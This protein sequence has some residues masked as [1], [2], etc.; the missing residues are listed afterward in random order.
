M[1]AI[2]ER[3]GGAIDLLIKADARDGNDRQCAI[4]RDGAGECGQRLCLVVERQGIGAGATGG[5]AEAFK[6]EHR[7]CE[8]QAEVRGAGWRF[9]GLNRLKGCDSERGCAGIA[10]DL[11][12]CSGVE[13]VVKMAVDIAF[14][15][16][17]QA[18]VC[19]DEAAAAPGIVGIGTD[20]RQQ[21]LQ[22]P[23]GDAAVGSLEVSCPKIMK[24]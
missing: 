16:S 2:A 3:E 1:R 20:S 8:A 23:G 10:V 13:D 5:E 18:E 15:A 6:I 22:Q 7:G 21:A 17:E 12:G 9:D 24:F 14:K 19:M 4:C 11:Y